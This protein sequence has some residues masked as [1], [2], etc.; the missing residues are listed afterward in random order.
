MQDT[1][2]R[3][4]VNTNKGRS[5]LKALSRDLDLT[6]SDFKKAAANNAQL[7][8]P[9]AKSSKR[10]GFFEAWRVGGVTWSPATIECRWTSV[11]RVLSRVYCRIQ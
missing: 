4:L 3:L 8:K 10:D 11:Y 1:V 6:R 9:V 5:L 2:C 7:I